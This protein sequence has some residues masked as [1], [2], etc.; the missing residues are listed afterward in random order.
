MIEEGAVGAGTGMSCYGLKGGIGSSSRIIEYLY[1]TYTLGV[2]VLSNFGKTEDFIL[3]GTR[4]GCD[5]KNKIE[6]STIEDKG[7]IIIVVATDLPVDSRQLNRI[8]KRASSGLAKTGSY[9]GHGSGDVVIG[10]STYKRIPHENKGLIKYTTIH[11][12]DIDQAFKAVAEATEEA[13]LNSM[14]AAE[15]TVG[16]EGHIRYSLRN[17]L[18]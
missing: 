7:S 6:Q 3:N 13:I 15:T 11:E 12:D 5:I 4:I 16:R 9:Y 17:F 2:L 10:F 14:V 8:I 18:F 1:G